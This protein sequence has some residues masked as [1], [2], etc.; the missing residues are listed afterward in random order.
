MNGEVKQFKA[1]N[2]QRPRWTR[3]NSLH[4]SHTAHRM[5][6]DFLRTT[7]KKKRSLITKDFSAQYADT[8]TEGTDCFFPTEMDTINWPVP[9]Q[10][11]VA[12]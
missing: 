2:W 1:A 11:D 7:S 4:I 3:S 8:S 10:W 12:L 6:V 9:L 5:I